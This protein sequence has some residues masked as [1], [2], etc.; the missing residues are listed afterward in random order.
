MCIWTW[1][2]RVYLSICSLWLFT[3]M[4]FGFWILRLWVGVTK[5]ISPLKTHLYFVYLSQFIHSNFLWGAPINI[6]IHFD[7][8]DHTSTKTFYYKLIQSNIGES[9]FKY[10]SF[11]VNKW[12][13]RQLMNYL[14]LDIMINQQCY[15]K[16]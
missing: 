4:M 15:N 12:S 2:V 13:R 1:C 10:I 11:L 7:G 6:Y 9:E 16:P 8:Y 14:M 3:M 5:V